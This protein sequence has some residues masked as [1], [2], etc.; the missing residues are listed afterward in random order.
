[1]QEKTEHC[2]ASLRMELL[3]KEIL[4]SFEDINLGGE[5]WYT[6]GM[7]SFISTMETNALMGKNVARLVADEALEKGHVGER[8]GKNNTM[9]WKEEV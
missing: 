9:G 3:R 7:D 5:V 4:I 1:M 2:Y 6:S 8:E